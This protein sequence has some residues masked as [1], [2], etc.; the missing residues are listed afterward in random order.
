MPNMLG[1]IAKK[2]KGFFYPLL[3]ILNVTAPPMSEALVRT[4]CRYRD[5]ND[6]RW[7]GEEARYDSLG[8]YV[9]LYAKRPSFYKKFR[10]TYHF[11]ENGVPVHVDGEG[12]YYYYVTV[13]Q[14]GLMEYGYFLDHRE[15][16]HRRNC[17]AA[18]EVMLRKQ[19]VRGGWPHERVHFRVPVNDELKAG[20]Y[21]GMAQG[22]AVS[23]FARAHSL[24]KDP[25]YREAAHR[26]LEVV[27]TPVERGG[28]LAKIGGLDFYEEY[29][30][31][32]S[33][34]TLNGFMFCLI[35]LYDGVR[36][37]QDE[38]AG[39]LLAR[40][41]RTLEAVLPL[42]DNGRL[43]VYDLRH[44]TN[45]G[46]CPKSMDQ[47]YHILHIKL[48]EVLNGIHPSPVFAFYIDKWRHYRRA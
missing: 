26:A 25:V 3:D 47:K 13:A 37:F 35:G 27:N 2:G 17:L 8:P 44:I 45:P 12:P 40:G 11:D 43:S 7:R 46:G 1:V 30:T 4:Y 14:Y 32:P 41:L 22:Q 21:C 36:V 10:D 19:D 5:L 20:W 34:Y 23:L 18:A 15:E 42:Y 29:P 24:T 38:L 31:T 28:V 16:A 6:L 48:L 33:S 39:E 9:T